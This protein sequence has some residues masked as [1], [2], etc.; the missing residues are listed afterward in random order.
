MKLRE[1]SPFMNAGDR[2]QKRAVDRQL[3]RPVREGRAET[4]HL[5]HEVRVSQHAILKTDPVRLRFRVSAPQHES[6]KINRPPVR[7]RVWA[8]VVAELAL[9]AE[10][11]R[12]LEISIPELLGVAV[13]RFLIERR[14]QIVERGAEIEAAPA[15]VAD[16]E[17]PLQLGADLLKVPK[18]FRANIQCHMF[19]GPG[20]GV[21]GPKREPRTPDPEPR[22]FR[23]LPQAPSRRF[24]STLW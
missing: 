2:L 11:H 7:G 24:A 10:I 22:G 18:L 17:H 21:R 1:V 8:V 4:S 23:M 16:V 3:I 14:E 6:R 15:A 19:R 13:D 5:A 20:P 12:A 9:V